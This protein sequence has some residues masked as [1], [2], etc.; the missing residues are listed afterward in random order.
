MLR[1]RHCLLRCPAILANSRIKHLHID[2]EMLGPFGQT[3][4]HTVDFNHVIVA[5]VAQL[6]FRCHPFAVA[7]FIAFAVIDAVDPHPFRRLAHIGKK[8]I[9][10][11]PAFTD[12]NAATAVMSIVSVVGVETAVLDGLPSFIG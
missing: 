7:G 3:L 5:A 4:L 1:L 8:V 12:S 11:E 6:F 2:T 9:E 10:Y